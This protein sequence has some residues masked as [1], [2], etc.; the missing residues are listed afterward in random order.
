M[1]MALEQCQHQAGERWDPKLVEI[2]QP[3]GKRPA[4]RVKFTRPTD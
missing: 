4:A 2:P 1:E 3:D